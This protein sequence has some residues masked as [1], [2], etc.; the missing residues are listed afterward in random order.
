M[1]EDRSP[2]Q[3]QEQL[4][5]LDDEIRKARDTAT[6]ADHASGFWSDEGPHFY[7]S[8]ETAAEDDQTIAPPG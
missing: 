6:Q 1:A 5:A 7:E 8:G 2:E 4:E 3:M